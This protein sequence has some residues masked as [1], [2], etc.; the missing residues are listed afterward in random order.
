MNDIFKG[1]EY[2]CVNECKSKVNFG[3]MEYDSRKIRQ[4]DIFVALEGTNVDGHRFIDEAIKNGASMIIA[5][6]EIKVKS[7]IGYYIVENLRKNREL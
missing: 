5:S 7:D 3:N 1:I 6:K 2:R 4:G